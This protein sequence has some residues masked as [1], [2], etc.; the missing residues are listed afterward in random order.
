[1]DES[2]NGLQLRIRQLVGFWEGLRDCDAPLR[3]FSEEPK[4]S[5]HD[6]IVRDLFRPY[7]CK[8]ADNLP[9][10]TY[11]E[12]LLDLPPDYTSTD[13]LAVVS[14]LVSVASVEKPAVMAEKPS[15][16]LPCVPVEEKVDLSALEGIRSHAGKKAKQA[17]KKA[18]QAK[19]MDSDNEGDKAADGDAG[20]GDGGGSGGD[21]GGAGA[22]GDPPGDGGNDDDDWWNTGASKKKDKKKKK[23][24]AW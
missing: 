4:L 21:A 14:S 24:N 3:V 5:E 11:E 12:S 13:S 8:R 7:Q 22:G 18:Q 10:P 19:W 23:K 15:S 17:A 1:M 20:N 6:G 2:G 9:P 16:R